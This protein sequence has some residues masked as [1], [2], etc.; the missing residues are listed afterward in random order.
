MA[1]IR[2]LIRDRVISTLTG[3]NT[4]GSN[5]FGVRVYP[6]NEASLPGIIVYTETESTEYITT[7]L[8]RTQMRTLTVSAEAYVRAS[9][10]YEDTLDTIA[11][12][13]E[14][15]IYNDVT[16]N[17]LAKDSRIISFETGFSGEAEQPVITGTFI[18]EVVYT[19]TEGT[20]TG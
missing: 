4:T 10:D 9:S 15:A 5:V 20:P 2:Q 8:P 3:L 11:A 17:G 13:I 18:I 1:H 14:A 6:M 12:E 19:S 7:S 16:L